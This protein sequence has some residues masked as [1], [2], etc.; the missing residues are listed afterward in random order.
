[1][2]SLSGATRRGLPVAWSLTASRR[3]DVSLFLGA[4]MWCIVGA[5][6]VFRRNLW[7]LFLFSVLFC[8]LLG[9]F[10]GFAWFLFLTSFSLG[11][12]YFSEHMCVVAGQYRLVRVGSTCLFILGV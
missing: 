9:F 6:E 8:C 3:V 1:M 12:F 2:V 4:N 11:D 10:L 7:F 5:S